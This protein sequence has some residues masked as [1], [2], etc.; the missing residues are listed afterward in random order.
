MYIYTHSERAASWGAWWPFRFLQPIFGPIIIIEVAPIIMF[1]KLM[2]N[3]K[4]PILSDGAF[5][6][7]DNKSLK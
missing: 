4:S 1:L 7:S 3:K 5:F 2:A 6:A